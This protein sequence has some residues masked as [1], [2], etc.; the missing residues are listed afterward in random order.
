MAQRQITSVYPVMNG[1]C[2]EVPRILNRAFIPCGL[3]CYDT[4]MVIMWARLGARLE[5]WLPN[6]LV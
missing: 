3:K 4:T 5:I 6:Q 1:I 2:D